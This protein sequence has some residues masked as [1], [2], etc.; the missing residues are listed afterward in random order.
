MKKRTLAIVAVLLVAAVMTGIFAACVTEFQLKFMVDGE[1]YAVVNT[2]GEETV[3]LPENP[4]KEGYIFDGWYWDD[5]I[6]AQPFTAESLLEQKLESDMA[7]YAKWLEEDITKRTFKVTFDSMSGS[8]VEP[9]TALYGTLVQKPSD[10][11]R[12][13]YVFV[14]WFKQ[15]DLSEEWDFSS[16]TLTENITLYAKWVSESDASGCDILTAEG[17]DFDA[18]GKTLSIKTPNSQEYFALSSALTVSP[19]ASWTVTSDAEG[20]EEVPSATV[21]L[22]VGDNTFYINITSGTQSNK[23]QYTVNIRRRAIYTV[24]YDFAGGGESASEQVEEDGLA[25]AKEGTRTGYTFS[26]WTAGETAWDFEASVVT[27]DI[28]L[29][30]VWTANSYSVTFDAAGGEETEGVEVTFGSAAQ[31]PVPERSGYTFTGWQK[32][33]GTAVSDAA[34]AVGEWN[35]AEDVSLTASWSVVTYDV[36]YNNVEGA[37]HSNPATYTVED[38]AVS[39]Q[40]AAKTGYTFLGWYS[41][42][43]FAQEVSEIDTSACE[44]VELWARW[45]VI[46]YTATFVNSDGTVGT[47]DF[48]IEDTALSEPAVPQRT[49]YTGAWE[50]YEIKAEDLTI[51]A[52]YTPITYDI[53]YENTKGAANNN[54]ATYNIETATITLA[55]ITSPGYTFEGWFIGEEKVESIELGSYG[56]ITLTA[57]WAVITYNIT[58]I[59][60]DTIG[61]LAEGAQLKSTYTIE[62]QFDFTPLVCHTTGYNFAGW[63]TQK[64]LGTGEQVTGID[65]GTIGDVTV[66]AQWGL[67]VYSIFY[68]GTEGAENSNPVTYTIESETFTIAPL[69]RAGYTFL[70]WFEAD[71]ETPAQTTVSTGSYGDLEFYA[72]WQV[73]GYTITY[74]MYDG[75]WEGEASP[76]AYTIEESVT[77]TDLAREGYFFA[78]WYSL[79][80]GGELTTG[81]ALGSTG[82]VTVYARWINFDP[83]GGSEINYEMEYSSSGLTKPEDPSK[84]YYDFGGWFTDE[85][86]EDEFDF[87]LPE[88]SL[89]LYAKWIPTEYAITYVLDGGTNN[90]ANPATYNVEESVTFAAPSKVGHTFNGWYSTPEFTSAPIEGIEAGSHGAV[91]VYAS[92]SINSYTISF[93]TN[94]GTSVADIEQYYGTDV[95]RPAD[96]ARTGYSFG[97]WF[98]D[99]ALRTPYVFTTMPA[100]DITVYAK[101]NVI[102]YDIIYNLDGGTN[103]ASNPASFNIE[104][105]AIVLREPSKRGYTFVGWFTDSAFEEQVGSIP[106]GSYGEKEFFACWEVIVYDIIYNMPEGAENP[107]PLTYTVESA[108]TNFEA[109]SFAGYTFGGFFTSE[110]YGEQ[111]T[112]FGGGAI[113]DVTVFAKFTP[114]SYVVW[115]DG[116][117]EASS[118]VTFDLNGASGEAPAAQTVTESATLSYPAAPESAGYLFGG[119]FANSACEGEAFDFSGLIGS[120]VTLYAKWVPLDEGTGE[121][122]MNGSAE[123]NLLGTAEK[124]YR[125]IPLASGNV[126]ITTSGSIDTLGSLYSG[127]TLLKQNDDGGSNGNFL[128]TYNVTAGRV[129]EIRVRAFSSSTDGTATLSLSGSGE[130]ADGGYTAAGNKTSVTFGAEFTLPVPEGENLQKFLGWQ[131]ASG[132]M[133]TDAAGNGLRA[134]DVA[135]ET[136]LF[137]KWERMEY[138]VSFVTSGG[139]PVESVTLEYGARLDVNSFV[140]T[141]EGK[142]FVGWYLTASDKEPYNATTM[143]D[144]DITLYAKWDPYALDPIKYDE[145]VKVATSLREITADDFGAICFDNA[146]NKVAITISMSTQTAGETAMVRLTATSNGKTRQATIADVKIYG[147]PTIT[148]LDEK[149]YINLEDGLNGEW[150]EASGTDTFGEET[151]IVVRIDEG[152]VAGEIVTVYI[153]SVDPAGNI[154]TYSIDNVKLYGAPQIMYNEEKVAIKIDDNISE[155]LLGV[156]AVDSFGNKLDV[157]IVGNLN[158]YSYPTSETTH[159]NYFKAKETDNYKIY[160]RNGDNNITYMSIY[161]ITTDNMVVNKNSYSNTS[162][163]YIRFHV[164]EGYEYYICTN[165]YSNDRSGLFYMY[166]QDSALNYISLYTG[167]KLNLQYKT[168]DSKSNTN[169]INVEYEVYGMPLLS[170]NSTTELKETDSISVDSLGISAKDSFDNSLDVT[171]SIQ[172]GEKKAGEILIVRAV[173]TDIAGNVAI[174]EYYVKIYGTPLITYDRDGIKVTEDTIG[175]APMIVT[176]NF[177]DGDTAAVSQTVTGVVGLKYP[178]IPARSGYVFVGWYDNESCNGIPYDFTADIRNDITLYAKWMEMSAD[179]YI[180]TA[181]DATK[182]NASNT[183]YS[184]SLKNTSSSNRTNIYFSAL[185]NGNLELYYSNGNSSTASYYR[186]YMSIYNVTKGITIRANSYFSNSTFNSLEFEVNAGDVILVSVYGYS[187]GYS[188]TFRMYVEGAMLPDDGGLSSYL[189][190]DVDLNAKAYDSFGNELKVIAN[191]E[192]GELIKGGYIVYSLSASD[193][194]GNVGVITTA[195]IPVYDENDIQLSY[196]PFNTSIIKMTSIGEEFNAIATD[197]FGDLCEI[198][199]ERADGGDI[200]AGE[201]QDIVIVATDK[202]GNRVV[203]DIITNIRVYDMPKVCLVDMTER[204]Y[205]Y[206]DENLEFL[207]ILIDSFGNELS[208]ELSIDGEQTVGQTIGVMISGVDDAG[209]YVEELR[210]FKVVQSSNPICADLIVDGSYWKTEMTNST[211]SIPKKDGY[212]FYG[213]I[214]ENNNFFTDAKGQ[215]NEGDQ[216]GYFKLSAVFYEEN[217]FA[218]INNAK[219]L[220]EM[221]LSGKYFLICDIDLGGVAWIPLGDA[222]NHFKGVLDGRGFRIYNYYMDTNSKAYAGFV[223]YNEGTIKNLQLTDFEMNCTYSGTIYAGGLVAYN[224]GSVENCSVLGNIHISAESNYSLTG[225]IGGLIGRSNGDISKCYFV[226]NIDSDIDGSYYSTTGGYLSLTASNYTGGLVGYRESGT[227]QNCYTSG[228]VSSNTKAYVSTQVIGSGSYYGGSFYSSCFAYTG[229]LVGFGSLLNCYSTC[230]VR[231]TSSAGAYSGLSSVNGY[232]ERH[233]YVGG[234]AGS[235]SVTNCY[236]AGDVYAENALYCGFIV[237]QGSVNNSYW[238]KGMILDSTR[239]EIVEDGMPMSLSQI[240]LVNFHTDELGWDSNIWELVDGELPTLK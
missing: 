147:K 153:D 27:G 15:A 210:E 53:T 185:T 36:T 83:E 38:A 136:T 178:A 162:Y 105:G 173:A 99:S 50:A 118:V 202:A 170:N 61:D 177:N 121:I 152:Y 60:D 229:G 82:N 10:P 89:T 44:D 160:Y 208:A 84:D 166:L 29:T 117:E 57:K 228:N 146:G 175:M 128:I 31:L 145:S 181:I 124:A 151:R 224:A 41:D 45:E 24:T 49:G 217:G 158:E 167:K 92:F 47:V 18:E 191:V 189:C 188:T 25:P 74:N 221:S 207:I 197:T 235:A 116:S 2:A 237:G 163:N 218:A 21:P 219:Q 87:S 120:D 127:G 46:T 69:S 220:Q 239:K 195:Q 227:I 17:F 174:K 211:L 34:G 187:Y 104:S 206:E 3:K 77:F 100:E 22:Q 79:A 11:T 9:V 106:A 149:D 4:T 6:W 172:E 62:E 78:G 190:A 101:W 204:D 183:Y 225:Y 132:V 71:G 70:G 26:G 125:F 236:A 230:E 5:G 43:E 198:N 238:Y 142:T 8:A 97:G 193:H 91:T 131:D 110:S 180:D 48:D 32:E 155:E 233:S 164:I 102:T 122:K 123:V 232:S 184:T 203:S 154:A 234:L 33:D 93:D 12:T 13:G 134:W 39:L 226:G 140:T 67:E 23:N 137:S 205:I 201:I 65:L 20:R 96:P 1:V 148:V 200:V 179:G 141:Q 139:S 68:R 138:E 214:D 156:T 144:H 157:E 81:I 73:V 165:E 130:V 150:F 52:V 56:D 35:I 169:S 109:A 72:K 59:Y 182:Y 222:S 209:N 16:D 95:T 216:Q 115:L 14:G 58:Y 129:Y 80:E 126:S 63:F 186:I 107:N 66:Y 135:S 54:P 215:I 7:V 28:T 76:A 143:P 113:G 55:D 108:L 240:M 37:T 112:S 133:Y 40:D 94:E 196:N 231:S 192:S 103:N 168:T 194:L 75:E 86:F 51:N 98:S 90:A 176:F 42:A 19:Y 119:W 171:I 30:A 159:Y 114:N 111:V 199:I 64:D 213:W 223:G 161:C 212:V 88:R 85:S